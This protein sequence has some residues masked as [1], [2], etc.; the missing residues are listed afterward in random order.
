MKYQAGAYV[1]TYTGKT[2][3]ACLTINMGDVYGYFQNI[4]VSILLFWVPV[5]IT[6][7][8]YITIVVFVRN[9]N[10]K[11]AQ[12]TSA[13]RHCSHWK[14][15]RVLLI[16]FCMYVGTYVFLAIFTLVQQYAIPNVEPIVKNVGLL[17]PYAN[18]CMNPVVYSVV[19][20]NFRNEC[21]KMFCPRRACARGSDSRE[22]KSTSRLQGTC[23]SGTLSLHE[24][25][26]KGNMEVTG[27]LGELRVDNRAYN[28]TS[29]DDKGFYNVV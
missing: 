17:M 4:Y 20:H 25:T 7:A 18:S 11:F 5:P 13:R 24:R 21:L 23:C 10:K 2:P 28:D 3:F 16:V 22:G 19:N 6:A 15:A 12:C 27:D 26:M 8:T 29:N 9:N 1:E 14:A